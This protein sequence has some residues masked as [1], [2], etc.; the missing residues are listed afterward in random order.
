VQF[1]YLDKK[2]GKNTM[3]KIIAILCCF[4]ILDAP[5]IFAQAITT[6]SPL[7]KGKIVRNCDFPENKNAQSIMLTKKNELNTIKA[8]DDHADVK[9][10]QKVQEILDIDKT[11]KC[12]QTTIDSSAQ[13]ANDTQLKEIKYETK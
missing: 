11:L 3:N 10:M 12:T 5:L 7:K 6:S 13:Q 4:F 8:N 9:R 2:N 1:I